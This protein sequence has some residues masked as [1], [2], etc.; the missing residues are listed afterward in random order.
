MVSDLI[1]RLILSFSV[2]L[3]VSLKNTAIS[4]SVEPIRRVIVLDSR[5]GSAGAVANAVFER[6]LSAP[7]VLDFD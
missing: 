5:R 1:S 4:K 7:F 2:S 6:I 3:L